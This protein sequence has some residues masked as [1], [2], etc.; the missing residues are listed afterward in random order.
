MQKKRIN[1]KSILIN[2]LLLISFTIILLVCIAG[3]NGLAL[4]PWLDKI[5]TLYKCL[6]LFI[7]LVFIPCYF[8]IKKSNRW[9]SILV[10][11]YIV[12]IWFFLELTLDTSALSSKSYKKTMYGQEVIVVE[13]K[14][15]HGSVDYYYTDYNLFFLKTAVF[16]NTT[17]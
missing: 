13:K 5:V 14:R 17:P 15:V 1:L 10:L 11:P 2:T 3:F 7:I 9:L 12:F 4:K 16:Y 8:L 6:V